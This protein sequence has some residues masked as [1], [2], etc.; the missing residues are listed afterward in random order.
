MRYRITEDARAAVEIHVIADLEHQP[1]LLES[2]AQCQSGNCSCPTD[3]YER[4][5]TMHV[6]ADGENLRLRLVPRPGQ[7]FDTAELRACL[8]YTAAQVDPE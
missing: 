6:Q 2:L 4:L 7:R 3:Q 8:D 5:E 1:Q